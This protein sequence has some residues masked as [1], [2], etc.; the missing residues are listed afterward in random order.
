MAQPNLT[1]PSVKMEGKTGLK[2]LCELIAANNALIKADTTNG[3][4]IKLTG[5]PTSTNGL[6][7]GRLW[8]NSGTVSIF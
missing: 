4:A 8:N 7:A 6:T 1:D 5:L 2:D 3:N